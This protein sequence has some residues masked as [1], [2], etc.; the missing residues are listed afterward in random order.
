MK[1]SV[2]GG[3]VVRAERFAIRIGYGDFCY[4]AGLKGAGATGA[5]RVA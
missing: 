5:G 2:S 1:G 3:G 4:H